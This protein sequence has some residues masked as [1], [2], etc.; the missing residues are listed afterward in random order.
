MG[1]GK[2]WRVGPNEPAIRQARRAGTTLDATPT[3]TLLTLD[4]LLT[5]LTLLTTPS[6]VDNGWVK[7]S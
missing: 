3:R 2:Q 1:S 6:L 4:T 5:V 7:P